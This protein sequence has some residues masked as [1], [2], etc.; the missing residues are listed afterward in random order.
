MFKGS[1]AFSVSFSVGAFP[2]NETRF[3]DLQINVISGS[4]SSEIFTW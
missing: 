2:E 3:N 4:A 1:D